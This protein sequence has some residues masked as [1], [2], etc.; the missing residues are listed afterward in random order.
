M[1]R[2]LPGRHDRRGGGGCRG[3]SDLRTA[4]LVLLVRAGGLAGL[5]GVVPPA[6]RRGIR[7]AVRRSA[8]VD[9]RAGGL[10]LYLTG[11]YRR[12]RRRTAGNPAGGDRTDRVRVRRVG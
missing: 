11:P 7:A 4:V 10:L 8:A 6:V 3:P 12:G 1:H 2:R 9:L 5:R